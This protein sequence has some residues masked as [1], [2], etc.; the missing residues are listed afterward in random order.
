MSTPRMRVE[1]SLTDNVFVPTITGACAMF[2][3]AVAVA[4]G[5][6]LPRL[7]VGSVEGCTVAI[8]ES[9]GLCGL[10]VAARLFS[11][12]TW[13]S[14]GCGV[15]VAFVTASGAAAAFAGAG[16]SARAAATPGEDSSMMRRLAAEN[17][18]LNLGAGAAVLPV[19]TRGE[20]ELPSR[21]LVAVA[22][23]GAELTAVLDSVA[24]A[25]A[26]A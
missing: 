8:S 1:I 3:T 4:V 23:S 22:D 21:A 20:S 7:P 18:V 13:D 2:V 26:T 16:A 12:A 9:F 6:G 24:G 15:C 17:S 5:S 25:G 11:F 10:G 14:D 19:K